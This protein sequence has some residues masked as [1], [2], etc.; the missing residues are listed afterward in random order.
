MH[1]HKTYKKP[2]FD[3]VHLSQEMESV[4]LNGSGHF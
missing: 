4:Q 2:T 3:T 1:D